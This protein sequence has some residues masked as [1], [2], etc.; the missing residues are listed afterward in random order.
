MPAI[1]PGVRRRKCTM[2][3]RITSSQVSP[4]KI[5]EFARWWQDTIGGLKGQVEGL[6][7]AYLLGDRQSGRGQGIALWES[8]EAMEAAMPQINQ[9]LQQAAQFT[10]TAPQ[11]EVLDV[12]GQV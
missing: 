11:F 7:S 10:S 1:V 3:A 9:V 12:L 2:I 8:R 6:Q 4:E 5:D